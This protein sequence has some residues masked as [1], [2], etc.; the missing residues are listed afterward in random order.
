ME[1][2]KDTEKLANE[3]INKTTICYKGAKALAA[4]A[5]T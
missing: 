5:S 3:K 2:K 4:I 1:R